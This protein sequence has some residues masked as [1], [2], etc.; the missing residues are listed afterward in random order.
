MLVLYELKSARSEVNTVQ[1]YNK[2]RKEYP[3]YRRSRV[4]RIRTFNEEHYGGF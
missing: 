1:I 4:V 2:L 3:L